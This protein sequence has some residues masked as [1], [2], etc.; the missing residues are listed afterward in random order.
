M[1]VDVGVGVGVELA[2][3]AV[4][5]MDVPAISPECRSR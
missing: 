1:D 5:L 4:E 3:V 2:Q